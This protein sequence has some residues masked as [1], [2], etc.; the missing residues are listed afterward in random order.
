KS[1]DSDARMFGQRM[2]RD[3]TKANAQLKLLAQETGLTAVFQKGVANAPETSAGMPPKQYLAHEVSDH[4]TTIALF[5]SEAAKGSNASLRAYARMTLPT[6]RAHLEL[7]Q[8]LSGT[9]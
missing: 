6:L 5:E 1:S 4:Q 8:R 9:P 7:A 2:V 3:H